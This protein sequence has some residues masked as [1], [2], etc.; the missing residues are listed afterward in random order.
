MFNDEWFV[1]YLVIQ[2]NEKDLCLICQKRIACIGTQS[3]TKH[4]ASFDSGIDLSC[5]KKAE[6]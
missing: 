5:D 6:Q 2:Q 3:I 4:H 1:K